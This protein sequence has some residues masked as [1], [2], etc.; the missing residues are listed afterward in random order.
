MG[1]YDGQQMHAYRSVATS[2]FCVVVQLELKREIC[3]AHINY[4]SE[5]AL[6]KY[7]PIGSARQHVYARI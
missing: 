6:T 2:A 5:I 3:I 4:R 7:I 1:S